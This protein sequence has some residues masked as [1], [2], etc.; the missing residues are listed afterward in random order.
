MQRPRDRRAD[1]LGGQAV[2]QDGATGR[3]DERLWTA[4]ADQVG[5]PRGHRPASSLWDATNAG[6]FSLF[7]RRPAAAV[8]R[9][10]PDLGCS[11]LAL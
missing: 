6:L 1:R 5:A 8:G 3:R 4:L 11:H 9:V 2:R 7:F 10:V